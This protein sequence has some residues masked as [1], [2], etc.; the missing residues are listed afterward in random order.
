MRFTTGAIAAA[1]AAVGDVAF[2]AKPPH[3]QGPKKEDSCR[4]TKVAILGGG[5]AGITAAVSTNNHLR[6]CSCLLF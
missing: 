2:A 5:M 4:K 1:I 3:A 6:S